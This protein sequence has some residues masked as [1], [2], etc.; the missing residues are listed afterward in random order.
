MRY[1]VL[2]LAILHCGSSKKLTTAPAGSVTSLAADHTRAIA[3]GQDSVGLTASVRDDNGK[4]LSGIAVTVIVSGT[5]NA[6]AP[7]S[8][9]TNAQGTAL[10]AL[11]S[12]VAETKSITCGT[13]TALSLP[14]AAG[15]AAATGS[16]LSLTPDSLRADGQASAT[17]TLTLK[18]AQGNAAAKEPFTLFI[19][20]SDNSL[21]SPV[22]ATTD[23]AGTYTTTLTSRTVEQKEIMVGL[24]AGTLS[25]TIDFHDAWFVAQAALRNYQ[26]ALAVDPGA[27]PALYSAGVGV[28][29]SLDGGATWKALTRGLQQPTDDLFLDVTVD[30]TTTPH[31]IYAAT[32][33]LVYVMNAGDD[34]WR[35][36]RPL[37]SIA[38]LAASGGVVYA[39]GGGD[40]CPAACVSGFVASYSPQTASWLFRSLFAGS[41]AI[42]AFAL[43]ATMTPAT[44][45]VAALSSPLLF[46]GTATG[47]VTVSTS[48]LPSASA[49]SI[50]VA[51]RADKTQLYA[52]VSGQAYV[53]TV[54]QSS[55]WTALT[56]G[57][58]AASSVRALAFDATSGEIVAAVSSVPPGH[59]S[60]ATL[61][62]GSTTWQVSPVQAAA[63]SSQAMVLV[64]DRA[65]LATGDT[66]LLSFPRATTGAV[67]TLSNGPI[68]F[69]PYSF[70]S[71][72]GA[73]GAL[74]ILSHSQVSWQLFV[75]H[76]GGR[77]F[78]AESATLP[79]NDGEVALV[80]SDKTYVASYTKKVV[81]LQSGTWQ[82]ITNDLQGVNL[83]DLKSLAVDGQTNLYAATDYGV[84]R[85]ESSGSWTFLGTT[86]LTT[87]QARTVGV[88]GGHSLVIPSS[89][90]VY[91]L[92]S[93][94][95]SKL[96][97]CPSAP[98]VLHSESSATNGM[99]F[100][101]AGA[102]APLSIDASGSCYVFTTNATALTAM[103]T[104][105][106]ALGGGV[107]PVI[108]TD[109]RG[110]SPQ[111]ASEGLNQAF[112][113]DLQWNPLTSQ[114][115]AIAS[116][117]VYRSDTRG[118]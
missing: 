75:S 48:G 27:T 3:D 111:P 19:S 97:G 4:P 25:G 52:A 16:Q 90:G 40:G 95:W 42:T 54:G 43:D 84:S 117:G 73:D 51:A 46:A 66:G 5:G 106:V 114:L 53:F 76:D 6:V 38:K 36:L 109:T 112:I 44:Y 7:A 28:S 87:V 64:K 86:G 24:A 74:S 50:V 71:A 35:A 41:G 116:D 47:P 11:T 60:L 20:G 55:A 14:F 45:Y 115:F 103:G 118:R 1:L 82:D 30:V 29:R 33:T 49:I 65:L 34:T 57:L 110:G 78:T 21:A 63:Y 61:A 92:S 17:I 80:V 83:Y 9:T 22:S 15:T 62:S 39:A 104:D 100:L 13:A 32:H 105:T 98:P 37:P 79:S 85:L 93:G 2:A 102:G 67:T 88:L 18:D 108:I 59:I 23:A 12:T 70:F 99:V 89:D 81:A 8:A 96:A 69:T 101:W 26:F 107:A 94:T 31:Q 10:F 113:Q 72:I 68:V 56:G 77:T 58:D 91:T